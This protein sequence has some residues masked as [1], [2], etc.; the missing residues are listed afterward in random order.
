MIVTIT[1]HTYTTRAD[2]EK[3]YQPAIMKILDQTAQV[4]LGTADGVDRMAYE[5]LHS[6]GIVR[7]YGVRDKTIPSW[8]DGASVDMT[9]KS[10]TERDDNLRKMSD[11]LIGFV[12]KTKMGLGSGSARNI[13][14]HAGHDVSDFYEKTRN[15]SVTIEEILAMY[16]CLRDRCMDPQ[17]REQV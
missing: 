4:V 14:A 11:T 13:V 7:L 9:A 2:Y 8:L 16:P 6:R 10:Y 3:Y 1:G 12:Y 17:S 15:D 5:D